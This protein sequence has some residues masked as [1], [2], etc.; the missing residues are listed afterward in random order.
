MQDPDAAISRA[1]R[2]L[3]PGGVFVTSTACIGDHMGIFRFIAPVGRFFGL[4]PL[5]DVFTTD[6]LVASLKAAGFSIDHQWQPGKG[7][8][9]QRRAGSW[10]H[11]STR[12]ARE[13]FGD[14]S[15]EDAALSAALT[16]RS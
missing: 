10:A 8:G 9:T 2:L 7:K 5:L 3:K 16:G 14:A 15:M 11:D 1:F 13:G 4:L 6:E 12:S